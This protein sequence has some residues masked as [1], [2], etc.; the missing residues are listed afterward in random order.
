MHFPT[1]DLT[2][3]NAV[4]L[5]RIEERQFPQGHPWRLL[6]G[7]N[8]IWLWPAPGCHVGGWNQYSPGY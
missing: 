5:G 6:D 8:T 4:L 2:K 7:P 1:A 3:D